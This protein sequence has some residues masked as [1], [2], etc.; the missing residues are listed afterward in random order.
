MD[1]TAG[2]RPEP[3]DRLRVAIVCPPDLSQGRGAENVLAGVL[4]SLAARAEVL[5]LSLGEPGAEFSAIAEGCRVAVVPLDYRTRGWF[6]RDADAVAARVARE[7]RGW[8][9]DLVVLYWEIWD[10]VRALATRLGAAGVPFAAMLHAMPFA[11]APPRPTSFRRDAVARVLR[12]RDPLGAVFTLRRLGAAVRTL[13]TVP[14]IAANETVGHYLR[15]YFPG[16]VF[17]EASPGSAVSVPTAPRHGPPEPEYDCVFMGKLIPGKGVFQLP[18]ILE[19]IARHR[20]GSRLLVL[21][22][23]AG[24]ADERRFHALLRRHGV[25]D[26]VDLAGWVRGEDKYRLLATGR[27]FVYPSYA[28]DTFAIALLEAL[29]CGVPAVTYDVP[30]ARATYRTPAVRR[31]PVHAPAAL[32]DAALAMLD[33]EGYPDLSAEALRFAARYSSWHAVAEGQ[34]ASFHRILSRHGVAGRTAR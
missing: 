1:G 4:P 29:A 26:R 12:D 7:A 3:D 2:P 6:V 17:A 21:G 25:A 9:A 27:V 34:L 8:R 32:A 16:L 22:T 14:L 18:G 24:R 20:P 31:V 30:F 13:R 15:T 28:G 23:F 11:Y 10:L 33:S 19:R 5:V